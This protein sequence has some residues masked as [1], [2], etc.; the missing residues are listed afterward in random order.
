MADVIDVD[1]FELAEIQALYDFKTQK[2]SQV[3]LLSEAAQLA[4]R[5]CFEEH[6]IKG[7][8]WSSPNVNTASSGGIPPEEI[9]I[10]SSIGH[11]QEALAHLETNPDS[12]VGPYI[13]H[14][15]TYYPYG[16]AIW[17]PNSYEVA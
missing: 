9:T 8:S 16:T 14:D 17:I 6:N 13:M 10:G 5:Q 2:D 11:S 12:F 7:V 1:H 3:P 4:V 15:G